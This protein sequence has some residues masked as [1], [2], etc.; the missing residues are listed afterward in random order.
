VYKNGHIYTTVIKP[1]LLVIYIRDTIIKGVKIIKNDYDTIAWLK[2]ENIF[3]NLNTDVF[4]AGVYLW[5]DGS[6]T[7]Q[8][9]LFQ[10]VNV[11]LFDILQNDVCNYQQLGKVFLMSDFN[12]RVGQKKDYITCD[13]DNA[14]TDDVNY[15]PDNVL[16]RCTTDNVSNSHGLKLIDLCISTSIRIANGRLHNDK[17]GA[18]TFFN[19]RIKSN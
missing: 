2:L 10:T 7:Y 1:K 9:E 19:Y 4:L 13:S 17:T 14:F 12:V 18:C 8:F 15:S 5:R 16:N 11:N 6:P 3:F